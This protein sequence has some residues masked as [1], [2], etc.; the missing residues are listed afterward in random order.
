[1]L[2]K[3]KFSNIS[4]ALNKLQV[5][6]SRAACVLIIAGVCV[7]L[8]SF[9]NAT[10]VYDD[11]A[12]PTKFSTLVNEGGWPGALIH[13]FF[14]FD[15]PNE[16]RTYGVSRTIQFFLWSLGGDSASVYSVFISTSHVI[17]VLVLYVLLIK[18]KIHRAFALSVGLIWL[19]SPFIWTSCFHHYS[20]LILPAQLTVIGAYLLVKVENFKSLYFIAALLGFLL[21]LTGEFHLV[22]APSIL[23]IVSLASGQRSALRGAI[24]TTVSM[25]CVIIA[26]HQIWK[27]F[28]A[29]NDQHHRFVL[30]I[31]H[32]LNYWSHRIDVAL[33]GVGL[34]AIQQVNE[35]IG[36]E[37]ALFLTNSIIFSLV[38]YV[39]YQWVLGKQNKNSPRENM[40]D[41]S[42][43]IFSGILL[44]ISV[45]YLAV[46]LIVTVLTDSVPQIMYRRYGYIPLTILLTSVIIVVPAFTYHR[47]KKIILLSIMTSLVIALFVHHQGFVLPITRVAD[48]RLTEMFSSVLE[49]YRNKPILFFNTSEKIFPV[50]LDAATP[51]PAM[52]DLISAEISQAKYGTYWP[53]Q[54]NL[55]QV[56]G[57]PYVCEIGTVRADGKLTL[58]C[59]PWQSNPGIVDGSKVII[60]ANLGFEEHDPYGKYV[61]VFR[62]FSEFEP[63]FFSRHIVRG[64]DWSESLVSDVVA[65]DLGT[66]ITKDSRD[67]L[68]DKH[69]NT[70]LQPPSNS[71]LTDYGWISGEDRIYSH[72]SVSI[73]SDYYRSN[74]NGNFEYSL[75]FYKANVVVD[76]DFWELWGVKPGQ[77]RFDIHVKWNETDWVSLGEFDPASIN[78]DKPFSIRLSRQNADSFSFRLTSSDGSADI[79]F[80]QGLRLSMQNSARVAW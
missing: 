44:L 23:I 51:G 27:S 2:L 78:G 21:A 4:Q 72:P 3:N 12:F 69:F 70:P 61:R 76:L 42:K 45:L 24:L 48:T 26:H 35:I 75:K 11:I 57:A 79:P 66:Y 63:Y 46:F 52:R 30:S 13:L 47:F 6:D 64:I 67:L 43:L 58:T 18:L 80:I 32:D 68:P 14:G 28:A 77:R 59:P 19:F 49:V 10:L 16:Y 31:S 22:A 29:T 60:I 54:Q 1:M 20:Y 33:K 71:W 62:D 50:T 41:R 36:H 8:V 38:I 37:Y 17:Y 34:S 9:L 5:A 39:C 40:F 65:L 15:L 73:N 74:R 56:L 7:G 25:C 55:T 53:A